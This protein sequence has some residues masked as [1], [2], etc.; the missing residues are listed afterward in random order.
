VT[1]S[2]DQVYHANSIVYADGLPT[3][4]YDFVNAITPADTLLISAAGSLTG[5][6]NQSSSE[7]YTTQGTGIGCFSR[8]LTAAA[9]VLTGDTTTTSCK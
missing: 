5:N 6:R 8:M 9:N 1:T 2:I 7:V 3:G 4:A